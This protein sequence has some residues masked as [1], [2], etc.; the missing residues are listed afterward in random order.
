MCWYG[1]ILERL[2][3]CRRW[4]GLTHFLQSKIQRLMAAG[5]GFAT[6]SDIGQS[7]KFIC[8]PSFTPDWWIVGVMQKIWCLQPRRG[9]G[10]V[11]SVS[12]SEQCFKWRKKKFS[13]LPIMTAAM[14]KST[15]EFLMKNPFTSSFEMFSNLFM[16]DSDRVWILA[17]I[18]WSPVR[19]LCGLSLLLWVIAAAGIFRSVRN[20]QELELLSAG[21]GPR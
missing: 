8:V 21:R 1:V 16:A 4:V 9:E 13:H 15:K 2:Q 6:G 7:A 20:T 5:Q 3:L 19:V 10:W 11:C 18:W 17:R 14:V 12:V